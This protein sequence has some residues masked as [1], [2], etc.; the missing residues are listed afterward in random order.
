MAA[1]RLTLY[2]MNEAVQ[3]FDEALATDRTSSA[4][5]LTASSGIDGRFYRVQPTPTTPAWIPYLQPVVKENLGEMRSSSVSGLLLIRTSGRMFALTFGYGRS[6]LD[7]SKIEYQFGL[8][9]ALNRID[10]T[11]LRSLDTKTFED[12]VVST[13]TQV[14]RSAELPAFKVNV[15]SD[16]LRAVTGRPRDGTL[17]KRLSGA[18]ALVLSVEKDASD[19]PGLCDSLLEAFIDD[20]YQSDFG[21]IDQLALV[22]ESDLIERLDDQLMA[23]LASGVPAAT[24]LAMPESISWEDIDA[25]KIGGTRSAE[26]DELDLDAYLEELGEDRAELTLKKLKSR[27]VSI[28]FARS[29]T[30]DTRWPLYQCL[31]S[32]HRL[33]GTLYVLIEGRW[34]AIS[35]SLVTEVDAF[36][37]GL[38]SPAL[39]LIPALSG[40]KEGDYNRRLADASPDSLLNLDAKIKRPGGAASGIELCDV[41]S[42]QGEFVHVKR[43]SRSA[44]LSHLF[45]QGSV[46]AQTFL[47]DGHFRDEIRRL[48]QGQLPDGSE[49]KW[50]D[51]HPS[52]DEHVDRTRGYRVTYAVIT[53][54]SK[55]GVD[56]LPFFSKLNLKQH[57]SQLRNL[58]FEVAVIRVPIS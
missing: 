16:I 49:D 47:G 25:F 31:V 15:A 6:L 2:L 18:D 55:S 7:L 37:S 45:A 27:R 33:D 52:G 21:W 30:F 34:F 36:V 28:R 53:N 51:L 8:R 41:F 23:D 43:R 3:E 40:E 38:A 50:L 17:A 46:S 19:L 56:W 20:S 5:E 39:E 26:Y 1:R 44:T 11:Q 48:V 54:S 14:S 22:R 29:D 35:E 32:E 13:N 57:G 58:G 12:M 9:V 10:P 24:H 4:M 42:D